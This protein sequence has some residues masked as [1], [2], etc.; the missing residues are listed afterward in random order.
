M[1]TLRAPWLVPLGSSLLAASLAAASCQAP[2]G[3]PPAAEEEP[4]SP[5][6]PTCYTWRPLRIGGGGWV[7][8]IDISPDGS[9][10]VV[11]TDTYGAYVWES[12]RWRQ[13]VTR[14]SMP[15]DDG[16][17][18]G[19]A[20][21]YE[22]RVAP[23]APSRLYM[24]YR[25]FV[26]RS[27]DRGAR[28]ARTAFAHVEM[29][30]NDP[31]RILG[32]KMAVDPAN[33]DVVYAGTPRDGLFVT[34]NGGATWQR[35]TAV[36]AAQQRDGGWPGITGLVFDASAGTVHGVTATAYASSHGQGVWRTSDGG[37]SWK[38]LPGGPR[39]VI[40]AAVARDG[41]FY[42]TSQ[43]AS[44]NTA[45]RFSAADSTSPCS[46]TMPLVV[47]TLISWPFTSPSRKYLA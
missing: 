21:V 46:V 30:A 4:R 36:P 44:P 11:R 15:A 38:E 18:A 29:D 28:W 39:S 5:Q 10:R 9:T 17:A 41:T 14:D 3:A 47:V 23:S 13:L 45:W 24:A 6:C 32:P 16:A 25:G 26:Y 35:V 7:T 19:N 27:D 2:D 37:V 22:I 31:S 42:A 33:P 20:G 8:G 1:L 34:I 43:D 40:R 12:G